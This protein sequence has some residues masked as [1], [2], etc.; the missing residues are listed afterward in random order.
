M[1]AVGK[2]QERMSLLVRMCWRNR[3]RTSHSNIQVT[4]GMEPA[5]ETEGKSPA[6]REV[7]PRVHVH[8]LI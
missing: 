5:K 1:E 3:S 4:Q 8:M 7:N 2:P 6:W